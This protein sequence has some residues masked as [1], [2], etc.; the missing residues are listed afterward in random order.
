MPLPLENSF[1]YGIP[2]RLRESLAPGCRVM[3]E[4]GGRR[5]TG[6][7]LAVEAQAPVESAR[8]RDLVEQIDP[9]PC[10]TQ[11]LMKLAEWMAGYYHHP[12]GEVLFVLLPPSARGAE[13]ITYLPTPLEPPVD[14]PE[15]AVKLYGR[16][17]GAGGLALGALGAGTGPDMEYLLANGCVERVIGDSVAN[18]G[19]GARWASLAVD[20][21]EAAQAARSGVRLGE[22]ITLLVGGPMKLADLAALGI[23]RDTVGRAEKRGW[24][25][26]GEEPD[27]PV[28]G[29]E[30]G[31]GGEKVETPTEAQAACL[32]RI[33]SALDSGEF[34]PFLLMG[35]TGSGKTEVYLRA[36]AA[37]LARGRGALVLVPEIGLTPQLLGRFAKRLGGRMAVLH[38]GLSEKE[39]GL[40]WEAVRRGEAPVV[41]GTRSAV[42]APVKN[43]GLIIIDEEHEGSY[44]QEEGFRYNAKHVAFVR[45]KNLG[46]A[47]VAGSATP[48]LESWANA[49][50]GK[51]NLLRLPGR[52]GGAEPP[53]IRLVDLRPEEARMGKRVFVGQELKKE[54]EGCLA[55]GEQALIFLNRR[56]FSPTVSCAACGEPAGCANCSVPMTLHRG[57]GGA[58]LVCHYC[59]AVRKPPTVCAN[60]RSTELIEL[61]A[62]TQKLEEIVT[63]AWPSARVLRLDRDAAAGLNVKSALEAFAAGEADILVGTQMVAKGHHFPRLTTVGVISADDSLNVPDFRASERTFQLLVQV[64]GRAGRMADLPGR[65]LVQTRN[66]HH[67]A[68]LATASG[69]YDGFAAEELRQREQA[70]FPPYARLALVRVSAT[71]ETLARK[72]AQEVAKKIEGL[73]SRR[74]VDVLGPAPSPIEKVKARFRH[75]ILLRATPRNARKLHD[76]VAEFLSSPEKSRNKDIRVTIDIDP[77]TLT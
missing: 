15:G 25:V 56:G 66:P 13:R 21:P 42:F 69:D 17:S 57:R 62:G 39:R 73:P 12:L 72:A 30:F 8:I 44:K 60:C 51:Y 48:D 29:G 33:E 36:A 6:F 55:R 54:V 19:R 27:R 38:S 61:G 32:S 35:V 10:I 11:E 64:A 65:V 9:E 20:A 24:V 31:F 46:A 71:D 41:V 53:E 23:A 40:Q 50:S 63:S 1:H 7:A 77:V 52:V 14:A 74:F 5:L 75:Q 16:L 76:L 47:I 26:V 3:V 59:G 68:L 67:P 37:A 18:R 49:L 70:G 58:K 28:E 22:L 34:S 43:L 45:A 4:F 2:H